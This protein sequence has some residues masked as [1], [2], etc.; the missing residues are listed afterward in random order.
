[1][2]LDR[3]YQSSQSRGWHVIVLFEKTIISDN[4]IAH[5]PRI[6]VATYFV[7][8]T[9]NRPITIV[10]FPWCP[11]VALATTFIRLHRSII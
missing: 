6:V 3:E 11:A 10:K 9:A 4:L 7:Q 8:S 5:F 1:M 2:K